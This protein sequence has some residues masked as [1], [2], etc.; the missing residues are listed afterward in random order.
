M[1][2]FLLKIGSSVV[3]VPHICMCVQNIYVNFHLELVCHIL[4]N[5]Q[6]GNLDPQT[7]RHID[8]N[9]ES[10]GQQPR[11]SSFSIAT[12]ALHFFPDPQH[13]LTPTPFLGIPDMKGQDIWSLSSI[14]TDGLRHFQGMS[15]GNWWQ[16]RRQDVHTFLGRNR[17]AG[18]AGGCLA[19]H[20]NKGKWRVNRDPLDKN[21]IDNRYNVGDCYY[22]YC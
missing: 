9:Q 21:T 22:C 4:K 14:C 5:H 20:I 6:N 11:S 17:M 13:P 3:V 15:Q 8:P 12:S 7:L 1:V 10:T 16:F 19:D 18:D 2:R